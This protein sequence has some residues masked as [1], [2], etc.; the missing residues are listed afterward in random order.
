MCAFVC[1]RAYQHQLLFIDMTLAGDEK[2]IAVFI[3]VVHARRSFFKPCII[4]LGQACFQQ[5]VC[6]GKRTSSLL[7]CL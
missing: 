5:I 7:L 2:S 4:I 3:P 6:G 1:L